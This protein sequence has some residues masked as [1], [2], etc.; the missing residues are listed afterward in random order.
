MNPRERT[1]I[2]NTWIVA[3]FIAESNICSTIHLFIPIPY[4]SV[5]MMFFLVFLALSLNKLQIRII[6]SNWLLMGFVLLLLIISILLN[7]TTYTLDYFSYF[8][9]F[10]ITSI[11]LASLSLDYKCLVVCLVKIYIIVIVFY[12][13]VQRSIFLYSPDYWSDQMGMA[14]GMVIPVL[15]S[16]AYI[17]NAKK[18]YQE[19]KKSYTYLASAELILAF[20]IIMFDCGTRGAILSAIIGCCFIL[21]GRM[22]SKKAVILLAFGIILGIVVFANIDSILGWIRLTFAQSSIRALNKFSQMITIGGADNGRGAYF[23]DA[24][25]MYSKSPVIGYGVGSFEN[26]HDGAYVHEFFLELMVEYGGMGVI[27]FCVGL[28]KSIKRTIHS[29]NNPEKVVLV[30]LIGMATMLLYSGSYWLLPSFWYTV[31]ALKNYRKSIS[32]GYRYD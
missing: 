23:L 14:Y 31:L 18:L 30:V 8:F 10:G 5:F 28:V 24:I 1:R 15:F 6:S 25:R 26:L 7:G 11:I 4:I 29:A 27:V 12:F 32:G 19:Y 22:K 17:V 16:F 21:L 9:V 2:S 20:Y 3:L 13:L